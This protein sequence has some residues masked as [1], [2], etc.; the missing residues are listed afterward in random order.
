MLCPFINTYLH[1]DIYKHT[2]KICPEQ[3]KQKNIIMRKGLWSPDE[4]ERLTRC[5][6]KYMNGTW[7]DIA[8]KAG[9]DHIGPSTTLVH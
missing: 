1:T 3:F 2:H 9:I 5:I 8:K 7:S 6:S 4:D